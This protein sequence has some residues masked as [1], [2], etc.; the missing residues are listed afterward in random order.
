[1]KAVFYLYITLSGGRAQTMQWKI[2]DLSCGM[3]HEETIDKNKVRIGLWKR[4]RQLR[5]RLDH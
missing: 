1:M 2:E 3:L 4:E 5:S